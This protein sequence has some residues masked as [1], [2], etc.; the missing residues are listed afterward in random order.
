MREVTEA[1]RRMPLGP[2]DQAVLDAIS[3]RYQVRVVGPPPGSGA[4]LERPRDP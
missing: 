2:P 4:V 3:D 1:P